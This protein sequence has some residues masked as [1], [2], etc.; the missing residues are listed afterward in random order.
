MR[1]VKRARVALRPLAASAVLAARVAAQDA[2]PSGP[3]PEPA[4]ARAPA[5]AQEGEP[6]APGSAPEASIPDTPAGR[7][8][9]WVLRVLRAG[10]PIDDDASLKARFSRRYLED[11]PPDAIRARL[12]KWRDDDFG[13]GAGALQRV[14]DSEGG[15]SISAVARGRTRSMNIFLVTDSTTGAIAGLS[16]EPVRFVPIAVV[17]WNE[18]NEL[19]VLSSPKLSFG[20]YAVDEA[21]GHEGGPARL[22]LRAIHEENPNRMLAISSASRLVVLA[23]LAEQGAL[24]ALPPDEPLAIRDELKTPAMGSL[25]AVP[26]GQTRTAEELARAMIH[27]SDPTATDHLI[28]RLGRDA[29]E[30]TY[31]RFVELPGPGVPFLFARECLTLKLG[32]DRAAAEDYAARTDDEQRRRLD[33]GLA[34]IDLTPAR[35]RAWSEPVL[36]D[37]VGWFASAR[38]LAE[39][40]LEALR[41]FRKTDPEFFEA[42]HKDAEGR[43]D[44]PAGTP[45][46]RAAPTTPGAPRAGTP[47]GAMELLSS[48]PGLRIDRETWPIAGYVGGSEPGVLCVTWIL[49]RHDGRWFAVA[50]VWNDDTNRLDQRRLIEMAE[51]ALVLLGRD[52][53]GPEPERVE[54]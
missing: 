39:I 36:V 13:P 1:L 43:V 29:V 20:A 12:A 27:L 22:T 47:L 3:D 26:A 48:N 23:C 35:L 44:A 46:E 16:I 4:R 33:D 18:L 42:V 45:D 41:Q 5:P 49:R 24:G 15:E 7:Q 38:E 8:L 30:R 28:A 19:L 51:G 14:S 17:D 21:P 9:Q 31:E 37:R 2:A 54:R 34:P 53:I 40:M 6:R 32:P 25:H 11:S 50:A 52:G 10:D